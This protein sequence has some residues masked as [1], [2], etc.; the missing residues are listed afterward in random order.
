MKAKE[1]CVRRPWRAVAVCCL[2]GLLPHGAAFS[3][4]VPSAQTRQC[5]RAAHPL[6]ATSQPD[7]KRRSK[8]TPIYAQ[9]A[10][11]AEVPLEVSATLQPELE[12]PL[13]AAQQKDLLSMF[14]LRSLDRDTLINISIIAIAIAAVATQVLSVNTGITRGWSAEEVAFR[15]PIDNWRSY[16]DILSVQPIQ[17]KAITSATV[18]TIGDIIAQRTEGTEVGELDRGRI[19]RSLAA[20]LIG[21][22]PLSHVWY[23]VSEDFFENVMH[24]TQ[25]W[26]FIPK[27]AIDQTLWGPFWNNTYIL[28]LGIM[29]FQKPGQIWSEVKR[30]TIPLIV[31]GLKLWPLAHCVTYGLVP[32][33]NRLLWVD[34]VEIIWVTILATTASGAAEELAA[35][36]EAEAGAA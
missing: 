23:Q 19:G 30:T 24:W 27:V 6:A 22:G 33:E 29:Q 9:D 13:G 36:E 31:S 5:S 11:A 4:V 21:H 17:T 32:V 7:D 34:M 28:L 25:W 18:Y 2:L 35:E 3:S 12:T 1:K 16:N 14:Q 8:A 15:V 20:G 26:S 10:K